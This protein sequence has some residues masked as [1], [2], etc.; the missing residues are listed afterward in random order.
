MNYRTGQT[1]N[2]KNLFASQ[3]FMHLKFK[4]NIVNLLVF[5]FLLL[6]QNAQAQNY[7]E[8][9]NT[10]IVVYS[11][12]DAEEIEPVIK[13]FSAETN[14][15]VELISDKF[16]KLISK[17]KL[18]ESA[19]PPDLLITSDTMYIEQAKQEGLLTNLNSFTAKKN[20]SENFRDAEDFWFG[21]AYSAQ[22]IVYNPKKIDTRYI[23]SYDNLASYILRDQIV[24]REVK[25]ENILPLISY[26]YSYLGKEQS[27][28]WAIRMSNIFKKIPSKSDF[29]NF[30][31]VSSNETN[32]A[33]ASSAS[34]F[35][36][37]DSNRPE[38][39]E[40]IKNLKILF[41]NQ[42]ETNTGP[43]QLYNVS[44][45]FGTYINLNSIGL[46]KN[47]TNREGAIK[48]IEFLSGE[49]AQSFFA[50][51][52]YKFPVNKS[53]QI[54]EVMQPHMNFEVDHNHYKETNKYR[55]EALRITDIKGWK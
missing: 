27:E 17:I 4:I 52:L 5:I 32:V 46:L 34:F 36:I 22:S 38:E 49:K 50:N 35:K 10:K 44:E 7:P 53:A 16:T 23:N 24:F 21:F 37:L 13:M 29:D 47:T 2:K 40:T 20:I 30:I 14:I 15:E 39:I 33:L 9:N 43:T 41:P 54:P 8:Q 28:N 51:K 12:L 1:Y 26:I 45:Y 19:T 42:P 3:I 11:S 55:T 31:S 6:A 18:D 48:F 25:D